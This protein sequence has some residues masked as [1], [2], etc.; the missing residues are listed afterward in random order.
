MAYWSF[1]SSRVWGCC[2]E[3]DYDD[4][5]WELGVKCIFL[6][7]D[8]LRTSLALG[9]I[10]SFYIAKGKSAINSLARRTHIYWRVWFHIFFLCGCHSRFLCAVYIWCIGQIL[11]SCKLIFGARFLKRRQSKANRERQWRFDLCVRMRWW[12]STRRIKNFNF[13]RRE[14]FSLTPLLQHIRDKSPWMPRAKVCILFAPKRIK[15]Q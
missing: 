12:P 3:Y 9:A 5:R 11:F 14:K 1:L 6:F 2:V 8:A 15:S 10:F 4:A 7:S 13:T